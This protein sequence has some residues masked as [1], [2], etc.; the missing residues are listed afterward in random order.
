MRLV[1]HG[2]AP[3]ATETVRRAHAAFPEAELMHLYGATETAPIATVLPHE[4]RF[5]DAPQ[6]R[7]CGQP[8][9][10]VEVVVVDLRAAGL[11]ARSARS[12]N[13]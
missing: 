13:C 2:G 7:S 12:G 5:L 9:V 11:P 8:A 3:V 10:G 6:V 4:E 1:S